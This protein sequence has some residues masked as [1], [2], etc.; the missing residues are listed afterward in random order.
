M[1]SSRQSKAHARPRMMYG[2]K[3]R[4][5]F[6]TCN[7]DLTPSLSEQNASISYNSISAVWHPEN[8]PG[9]YAVLGC[10]WRLHVV[11]KSKSCTSIRMWTDDQIYLSIQWW[12]DVD[13]KSEFCRITIIA[14]RD[15]CEWKNIHCNFP[16][17]QNSIAD[18]LNFIDRT[19]PL[20]QI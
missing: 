6:S 12:F 16:R 4:L 10:R 19:L 18:E 11:A 1:I 5:Q 9:G 14:E 20:E 13:Q 3:K 2:R 15:D 17:C 7:S 8:N